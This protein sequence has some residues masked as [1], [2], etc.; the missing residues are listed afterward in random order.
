MRTSPSPHTMG[1]MIC[2]APLSRFAPLRTLAG[3]GSGVMSRVTPNIATLK[4]CATRVSGFVSNP[5]NS[6]MG[7]SAMAP[8]SLRY[9]KHALRISSIPL[10][11][12]AQKTRYSA[13]ARVL[14][15]SAGL[16]R[17]A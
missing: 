9:S 4:K 14:M 7:P 5:P 3:V 16:V 1:E 2:T 11:P 17:R 12:L 15:V 8:P 6:A 10:S 13:L